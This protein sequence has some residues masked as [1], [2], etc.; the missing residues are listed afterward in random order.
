MTLKPRQSLNL[1]RAFVDT[2]YSPDT[3]LREGIMVEVVPE[4]R[5]ALPRKL[6]HVISYAND[7]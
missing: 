5:P 4:G 1:P 7:R 6:C 3:V 2:L